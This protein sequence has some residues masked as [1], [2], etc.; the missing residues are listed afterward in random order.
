MQ[1]EAHRQAV[2]PLDLRAVIAEGFRQAA[3]FE[4][5]RMEIVAQAAQV[6]AELH[7]LRRDGVELDPLWSP[8]GKLPSAPP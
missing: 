4:D 8:A 1:S 2:P 6:L 7:H 5:R 3:A